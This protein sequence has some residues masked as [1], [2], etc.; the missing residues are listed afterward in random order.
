VDF[1]GWGAVR[2]ACFGEGN[3]SQTGASLTDGRGAGEPFSA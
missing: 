1:T 3:E 2:K